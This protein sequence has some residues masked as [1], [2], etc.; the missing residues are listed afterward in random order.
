MTTLELQAKKAELA[1]NILNE[2][3]EEIINQLSSMYKS[4]RVKLPERPSD[5]ELAAS[6]KAAVN[7]YKSGDTKKFTTQEEMRNRHR[8]NG[9]NMV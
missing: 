4:M 3:D 1:R 5:A 2:V 6:A 8:T 9:N 7:A